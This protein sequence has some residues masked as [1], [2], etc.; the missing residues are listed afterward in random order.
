ATRAPAWR[1]QRIPVPLIVTGQFMERARDTY[2]LELLSMMSGYELLRGEDL[3]QGVS[4]SEADGRHQCGRELRAMTLHLRQAY[5]ELVHS[6]PELRALLGRAQ[7]GVL[8]VFRGL[9]FL[10]EGPWRSHGTEF[11]SALTERLE[12]PARLVSL[13]SRARHDVTLS[14]GE[15][16]EL[17]RAPIPELERWT[18]RIDRH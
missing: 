1:K 17:I 11:R 8:A 10:T 3:L 9:L 4:L 2:P 13:L 18:A 5:V 15:T 16:T 7:P 14:S 6:F 12:I